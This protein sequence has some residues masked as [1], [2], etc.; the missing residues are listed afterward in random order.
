MRADWC[1]R[2]RYYEIA[3]RV[4]RNRNRAE[5]Q[6]LPKHS[7]AYAVHEL[8]NKCQEKN[9]SLRIQDF[10]GNTLPEGIL[11]RSARRD[12]DFAVRVSTRTDNHA[13]AQVDEIRGACV[14]NNRKSSRR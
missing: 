3:R 5:E 11:G 4:Q 10:S 14:L 9:R 12:L 7:T 8:R 6:K 13:D 2:K 1:C